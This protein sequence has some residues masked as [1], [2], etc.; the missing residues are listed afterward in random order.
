MCALYIYLYNISTSTVYCVLSAK[1]KPK[2]TKDPWYILYKNIVL[3]LVAIG[4]I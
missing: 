3:K 4:N 1:N 2:Q